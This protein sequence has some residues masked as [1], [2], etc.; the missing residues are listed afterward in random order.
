MIKRPVVIFGSLIAA[1][2]VLLVLLLSTAGL[3]QEWLWMRQVGYLDIFWRLLSIRWSLAGLSFLVVFFYTWINLRFAATAAAAFRV[4]AGGDAARIYTRTGV[5]ISPGLLKAGGLVI[6]AVI[7]LIFAL[8]FHPEW[9]TYLRFHYGAAV[10]R[11]DPVFGRD[12][13]FYLFRLPFYELIQNS[14][15]GLT[16]LILLIVIFAYS[17]L[18][19]FRFTPDEFLQGSRKV[20][21]HLALLFILLIGA[22]GW[23][24]YL[25]RFELLYS[26]TGVVYGVGYTADN[27]SRITLWI[28][29]M[30]S[31][32]LAIMVAAA[33]YARRFKMLLIS[34]ASYFVLYFLIVVILPGLV[35]KFKVQPSELELETPYLAQ[36]IAFTR[37]AFQ[38]DQITEKT[39]PALNDLTLDDI[40]RSKET[41][42]NIRIWDWRPILQTY[43]QTQ[44]IRLY[45]QF[46]QVDVDRYHLEDGYHQVMLSAREL[47]AALPPKARTW[48][49]EYLQ[50]THGYG[51]VMNF[52]SKKEPEGLPVYMIDNIPPESAYNMTVD[53]PAIYYGEKTPGYRIV[54]TNVKEF[55]YPQGNQNVYTSYQGKGGIR[56]DRLWKR[57]LFAW[58]QSDLNILLTSYLA[59]ESR[60]Q[61]W[62]D[63]HERVTRIAPFLE[64]D[65][66]PYLVL[67]DGKLYWIQ[68]AYTISDRYP[69]ST[70]YEK[71]FKRLN[72]IRNS[73]KAVVDVYNG[74]VQLYVM[75]P[76]DPVLALY[77]RAFPDAFKD[78]ADMPQDLKSHLRYPEDLFAIQAD[79]YRTYHMTDP[80]VFYNQ[81]DLW[82]FPQEKYA[83]TAV[84]FE[85][86]YILMRLPGTKA[87][88]YLLMTPFTPQNRDNMIAWLAA[89]C[90]FPE[91]GHLL[92]YQLPK[93]RLTFGPIQ[94]EAMIDQNTLISEQL[95]LW[96]QKG[97]R[98]IR[99]NLVVIPIDNSFLY[100]EPVYLIAEGINIPQLKRIIVVQG[101]K[102]V[103][104]PT[105]ELALKAVFGAAR[106]EKATV[107]GPV[108]SNALMRAKEEFDKA[109][110]ALEQG[111]WQDFGNAM[112]EL[113]KVLSPAPK[114]NTK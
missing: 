60:I 96:D 7:G 3:L 64:L 99:G 72:Y 92:V 74:T 84:R 95:S 65:Q 36:N 88:E 93:K 21:G 67:S 82:G 16:L 44:E 89:K 101:D 47:A 111:K 107:A 13:G 10:G 8:N 63:V 91:Y 100:V 56:L 25:D 45:Y 49:N 59:P 66:D 71:A 90:D 5:A 40:N 35:Q 79:L 57:I 69:Y 15:L 62:R 78:L 55:D 37:K 34:A 2:F 52:V 6:A 46:Y 80:Q 108:Q 114:E 14:L 20:I 113:K 73:V 86:Y 26:A 109:Q 22:W 70:P 1:A 32:L 24:Y 4:P 75:D 61:I 42:D 83:G 87:L 23:G 27:V 97:S 50:F 68:D 29:V 103:M 94:I 48:V 30:A 33:F 11:S 41:I 85:P 51:L 102:V 77:W 104:E 105:L 106:P 9:D 12:V 112:E 39:Y 98:V 19:I 76:R 38:L 81:E 31:I 28:M 17:Y 58:T 43:R 54:A 53:Q 18:G 110:Q